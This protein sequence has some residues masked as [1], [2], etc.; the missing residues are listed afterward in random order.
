MTSRR[1]W[2]RRAVALARWCALAAVV[3]MSLVAAGGATANAAETGFD[4]AFNSG[5][6]WTYN[7]SPGGSNTGLGV[8]NGTSPAITTTAPTS[9]GTGTGTEIASIAESQ[10]GYQDSPAGTFCNAY[11]AYWG[12]GTNCGNGNYAEEWCAD[13]AA[14]IWRQAGVV[15]EYGGDSGDLNAAA[16]SFY[17]WG[18][19]NGTRHPLAPATY[20]SQGMP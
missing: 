1:R 18:A 17:Q 3:A 20:R 7:P 10:V 8:E 2:R 9:T 15:F 4:V 12:A 11:S 13:F 19:D 5:S 6:L 16:A 14:W